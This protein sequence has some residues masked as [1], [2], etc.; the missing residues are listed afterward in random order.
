M[1]EVS[2]RQAGLGLWPMPTRGLVVFKSSHWLLQTHLRCFCGSCSFITHLTTWDTTVYCCIHAQDMLTTLLPHCVYVYLLTGW[3]T[4][5]WK[6]IL[7]Y[8]MR[9]AE[10]EGSIWKNIIQQ[11]KLNLERSSILTSSR[12]QACECSLRSLKGTSA[13]LHQ[14]WSILQCVCE[15]G[16]GLMDASTGGYGRDAGLI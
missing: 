2:G 15:T 7:I 4:H 3:N 9:M 8:C 11:K 13:V 5:R 1:G 12:L 14:S 6:S 16:K 10:M